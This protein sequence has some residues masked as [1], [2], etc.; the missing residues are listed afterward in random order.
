MVVEQAMEGFRAAGQFDQ[1]AFERLGEGVEE[2][3]DS[4]RLECLEPWFTPFVEDFRDR[5]VGHD[6]NVA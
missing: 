5:P 2:A 3:P 4:A 1:V 6:A